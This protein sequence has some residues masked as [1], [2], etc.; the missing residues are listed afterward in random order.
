MSDHTYT[1]SFPAGTYYIGDPCY[2]FSAD[3]TSLWE[4]VLEDANYFDTSFCAH[5]E[6]S[7]G[8]TD[9]IHVY[10]MST[11]HGDGCYDFGFESRRLGVDSGML[12]IMPIESVNQIDHS[13]EWLAKV[14]IITTIDDQFTV[15]FN[16][17]QGTFRFGPVLVHTDYDFDDDCDDN[18]DY[19]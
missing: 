6:G 10:A 11:A 17:H 19:F 15:E 14:G 16:R 4:N 8:L 5:V 3:K 1:M 18:H 2:P 7:N 12:G 9:L 13:R